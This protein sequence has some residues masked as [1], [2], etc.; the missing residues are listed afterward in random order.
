[1]LVIVKC[2]Q[3]QAVLLFLLAVDF[4]KYHQSFSYFCERGDTE[5]SDAEEI[6][7]IASVADCQ[8]EVQASSEKSRNIPKAKYKPAVYCETK[9]RC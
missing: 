1:M 9:T 6:Q 4:K 7:P 2:W 3:P 8:S 5:T